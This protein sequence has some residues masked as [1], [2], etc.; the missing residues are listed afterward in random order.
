MR[1]HQASLICSFPTAYSRRLT[2]SKAT[3][4]RTELFDILAVGKGKD[5]VFTESAAVD[6]ETIS[7]ATEIIVKFH[8]PVFWHGDQDFIAIPNDCPT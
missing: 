7:E 5:V 4:N 2:K 3:Y 6:R 1:W 8:C